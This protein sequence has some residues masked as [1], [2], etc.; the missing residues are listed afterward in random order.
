MPFIQIDADP[1]ELLVCE[2]ELEILLFTVKDAFVRFKIAVT[3]RLVGPALGDT[4]DLF[5][6][7]AELP[8]QRVAAGKS[9]ASDGATNQQ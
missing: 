1:A 2:E 9:L 7:H 3:K 5:L 8:R 6:R 4:R